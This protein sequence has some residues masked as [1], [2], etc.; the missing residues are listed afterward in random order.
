MERFEKLMEKNQAESGGSFYVQSKIYW[1]KQQLM[2]DHPQ[3]L[4]QSEWNPQ[5]QGYRA[6]EK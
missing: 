6:N 5:G 1:A 3:E 4:N 2:I